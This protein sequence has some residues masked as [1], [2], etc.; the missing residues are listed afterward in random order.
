[1]FGNL[2]FLIEKP[3]YNFSSVGNLGTHFSQI[4]KCNEGGG[5]WSVREGSGVRGS[6]L[7]VVTDEVQD[8]AHCSIAAARQHTEVRDVSEEVQPVNTETMGC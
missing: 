7:C 2:Y 6:V 3:K 8:P 5:W 4:N 1:M